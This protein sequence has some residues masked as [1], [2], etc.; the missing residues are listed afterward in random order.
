MTQQESFKKRVR[1]RM[2]TTGERYASA[3][4]SLLDGERAA[5]GPV[6]MSEPEMNDERVR[7]ATGRGWDERC[8]LI[9]AWPGHTGGHAAVATHVHDRYDVTYWWAQAITGGWERITGRRLPNQMADGTFTAGKSKTV[10]VAADELRALLFDAD[11]RSDLFPGHDTEL[12]SKPTSKAVRIAIGPGSALFT[13]E[14]KAD[15]RTKVTVSHERL[16]TVD[17]LPAWKFFWGEWLDALSDE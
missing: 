3:R 11:A 7:A 2:A 17:E 9:D 8:D 15:G 14:P 6:W 16:T 12:R 5:G 1:A 10:P 4:R 13:I